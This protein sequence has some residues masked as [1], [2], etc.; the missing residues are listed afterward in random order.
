[1]QIEGGNGR[2]DDG[3]DDNDRVLRYLAKVTEEPARVHGISDEVGSLS[4]G[5]I[6]TSSCGRRRTS[7]S[8]R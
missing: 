6:A 5:R 1:M 7:G 2:D 8:S 3:L 4:P